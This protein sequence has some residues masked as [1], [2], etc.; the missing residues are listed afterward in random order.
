MSTDRTPTFSSEPGAP[1]SAGQIPLAVPALSGNEWT[2]VKE[3]LDTGWV[4]SVGP[5]VDRFEREVA[6]YLGAS[7]A[8][9]T[10]SGTAALHVAM[11]VA[12]VRPDDEVLVPAL[13][14]IAPANA[15]RYVGAW[16][17]VIDVEP[18][19]WQMDPRRVEGFLRQ[20]CEVRHGLLRNRRTGRRV[21]ALLPVHALGHP[22]DMDPLVALAR[23]FGLR[24]IEDA[25]ESLGAR[26]RGRPTGL[27]G[28]VGC[29]SFNGNKLIT[30]GGGGMVVTNDAAWAA[31]AKYLTTQAKDDPVE[32]V[33]REI[34]YNYRLTNIQAAIGCAQ[35]ERVTDYVAAKRRIASI[36]AGTLSGVPG[37]KTMKEAPWAESAWWLYTVLIDPDDFGMSSRRLMGVLGA[38]GIQTRPLWQPLNR[39]PVYAG[40]PGGDCPIAER[41]H[42]EALSLPSSIALSALDQRRVI[43][44][45]QSSRPRDARSR[46]G[47]SDE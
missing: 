5:F 25:T 26:Y 33:H 22:C 20:E 16:P 45:I 44:T 8:V 37:L 18:E 9:A 10:T 23:E 1:A 13:T 28:D 46:M 43:E 27:L 21:A 17:V 6:A 32:Y 14:F 40:A 42:S 34:G 30:T 47:P 39:S 38:A 41:I 31:K 29:L 35:L 12:G 19:F 3:C 15:V 4:S 2:Y 24:V 36:Y 7:H 11:L